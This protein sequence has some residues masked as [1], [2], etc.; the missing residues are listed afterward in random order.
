MWFTLFKMS[1]IQLQL[2]NLIS[3]V[4]TLHNSFSFQFSKNFFLSHQQINLLLL[5]GCKMC[6]LFLQVHNSNGWIEF[7]SSFSF[8]ISN[9]FLLYFLQV[10]YYP[11][12]SQVKGITKTFHRIFKNHRKWT[13]EMA[14]K[15]IAR[16]TYSIH[17]RLVELLKDSQV[18]FCPHIIFCLLKGRF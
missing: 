12:I 6:S 8:F 4:S 14:K 5:S 15:I 10:Q 1:L 13:T 7:T 9:S 2:F 16:S 17:F 11:T 18:I 3:S